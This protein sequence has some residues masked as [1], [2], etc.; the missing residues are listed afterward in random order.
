MY[1]AIHF[2]FL[3]SF[4]LSGKRNLESQF[5][6]KN[7]A[8]IFALLVVNNTAFSVMSP[9]M[10]QFI[11]TSRELTEESENE[12]VNLSPHTYMHTKVHFV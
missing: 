11:T 6:H 7:W 12:E 5:P 2:M 4:L 1:E 9:S 3:S 10:Y 8:I